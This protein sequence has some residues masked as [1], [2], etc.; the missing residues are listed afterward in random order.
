LPEDGLLDLKERLQEGVDTEEAKMDD[1]MILP[2]FSIF[3]HIFS[4]FLS[5]T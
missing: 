1:W 4:I 2:G 5:L 3:F